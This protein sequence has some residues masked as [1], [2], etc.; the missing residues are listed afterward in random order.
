MQKGFKHIVPDLIKKKP[1]LTAEEYAKIA[2]DQGLCGSDS[3][4]PKF[5][6][7]ST[8]R[9]E[10]REGRLPSIRADTTQKPIRYYPDDSSKVEPFIKQDKPITFILLSD[11]SEILDILLELNKFGNRSEALVWLAREGINAKSTE[12]VQI[13]QVVKKIN[14]LKQSVSV[15]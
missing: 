4:D 1:G 11:I 2:L 15:Q 6:L 5:S 9:K 3:M 10:V 7:A 14:E 8:L 13:R 12:L